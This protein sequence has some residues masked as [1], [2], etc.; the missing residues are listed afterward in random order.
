MEHSPLVIHTAVRGAN[1]RPTQM[2]APWR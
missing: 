2:G 1:D